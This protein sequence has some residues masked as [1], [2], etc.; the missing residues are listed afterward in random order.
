MANVF[1]ILTELVFVLL[2]MLVAWVAVTGRYS[3]NR[4]APAWIALGAFLLYWGLRAW[5][6]RGRGAQRGEAAAAAVRGASLA[7]VGAMMLGI[8]VMPLRWAAPLLGA[9]GV[10][11]MV[12]GLLSTVLF[13]R[14]S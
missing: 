12:R 10:I 8:A 7:L 5:W 2:G 6:R 1:R 4:R 13:A 11:L 9:A 3:F 14:I